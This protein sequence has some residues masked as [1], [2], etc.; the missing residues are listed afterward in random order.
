[1]DETGFVYVP[2]ACRIT[3]ETADT[4][5]GS[6]PGGVPPL[7]SRTCR[8]HVHYH[9]C[10]GGAADVSLSYMLQNALPAYA[11]GNALVVL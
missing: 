3:L 4:A 7:Y 1:M 9:P 6:V 11:E 10:G 2:D 8:I 5:P